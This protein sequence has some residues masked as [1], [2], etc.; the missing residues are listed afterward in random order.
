MVKRHIKTYDLLRE[1][2]DDMHRIIGK[3]DFQAI[4]LERE[5]EERQ[6]FRSETDEE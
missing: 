3:I 2:S 5:A 6:R 1:P 4:H